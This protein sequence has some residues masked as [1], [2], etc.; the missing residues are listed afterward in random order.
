MSV[1]VAVLMP[2]CAVAVPR[3]PCMSWAMP[4]AVLVLVPVPVMRIVAGRV[5][6][7]IVRHVFKSLSKLEDAPAAKSHHCNQS[8]RSHAPMRAG[9]KAWTTM[10]SSA[11][12]HTIN[13]PE[14]RSNQVDRTSPTA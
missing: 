14:G 3:L 4:M 1:A 10:A 11:R 8:H 5:L 12:H 9:P 2:V 13:A 6:M 7:M